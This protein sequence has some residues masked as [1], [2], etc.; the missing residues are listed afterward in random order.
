MYTKEPA[1]VAVGSIEGDWRT[2]HQFTHGSA[3]G[4]VVVVD[5]NDG[6]KRNLGRNSAEYSFLLDLLSSGKKGDNKK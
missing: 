5:C 1:V 3:T 2:N 6:E 4:E